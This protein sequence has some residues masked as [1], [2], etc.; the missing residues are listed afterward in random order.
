MTFKE[1][2]KG[3][4][5]YMLDRNTMTVTKGTVQAVSLPRYDVAGTTPSSL[6]MVMDVTIQADGNSGQYVVKD[7]AETVYANDGRLLITPNINNVLTELRYIKTQSEDVIS[8]I[9]K[10]KDTVDKCSK[11]LEELD[12]VFKK[13]QATEKRFVELEQAIS[14]LSDSNDKITEILTKLSTNGTT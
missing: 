14:K 2:N 7:T 4:L 9:D 1:I 12:P 11:L 6:G 10:H 13:D 8:S 3:G 5:V